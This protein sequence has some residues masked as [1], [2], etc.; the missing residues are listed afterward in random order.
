MFEDG[1]E[2]DTTYKAGTPAPF[3]GNLLC[4]VCGSS[5]TS[6]GS[7]ALPDHIH[8]PA[9]GPIWWRLAVKSHCGPTA[10]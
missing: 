7:Q 2:Y 4:E 6:L 10:P 9:Q 5:I 3:P 8:S 1:L